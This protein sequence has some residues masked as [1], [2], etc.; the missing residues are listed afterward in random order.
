[1]MFAVAKDVTRPFVVDTT[2]VSVKAIGTS[3]A[4]RRDDA[5]VEILVTEGMVEVT[6]AGV[7]YDSAPRRIAAHQRL[8][9]GKAGPA[10]IETIPPDKA[11]RLLAWRAGVV[12]FDGE[13]L[14]NAIAEINRYNRRQIILDDQQLAARPLV[15][16]FRTTDVQSFVSAVASAFGADVEMQGDTIRLKRRSAA[17]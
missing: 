12:A 1:M 2:G 10:R 4:V 7:S 8:I 16:I 15:G 3:F 9:V 13:P 17:R 5:C 14:S 6:R 11:E